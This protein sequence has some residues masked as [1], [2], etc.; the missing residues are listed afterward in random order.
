MRRRLLKTVTA[1]HKWLSLLVGV[2]VLLWIISGLFMTAVPI[3]TVRSE[4]NIRKTEPAPFDATGMLSLRAVLAGGP[5]R[6]ELI[7]LAGEPIWR[8]DRAGKP[9]KLVHAKTGAQLAPLNED[10]ARAIATADFKGAGSIISAQLIIKDPHIEYRGALPVWRL[11]FS[12]G[13]ETRIYV[14]AKTGKVTARRTNAWRVYDFLWSLHI[15]D[16][17]AREDFNHPLV[18]GFTILALLLGLSGIWLL[19][20]RL[21]RKPTR[22]ARPQG[23][24]TTLP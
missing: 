7:W 21:T 19:I 20:D 2:Q 5:T 22:F 12:D 4:H 16:Y 3:E 15:M 11:D 6:A 24:R 13:D 23:T 1:V 10:W 17:N 18:I 8:L 9:D 14:D